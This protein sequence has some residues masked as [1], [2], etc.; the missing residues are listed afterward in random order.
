MSSP[1]LG[2]VSEMLIL[3]LWLDDR[4]ECGRFLWLQLLVEN[5][6]PGI[7]LQFGVV[8]LKLLL[9]RLIRHDIADRDVLPVVVAINSLGVQSGEWFLFRRHLLAQLDDV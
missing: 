9:Q 6:N 8:R 5:L 7:L 2:R 3:W 4:R 1:G